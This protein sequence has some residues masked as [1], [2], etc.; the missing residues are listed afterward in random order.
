MV[1]EALVIRSGVACRGG[2]V[3]YFNDMSLYS[4]DPAAM[5]SRAVA[6]LVCA[7]GRLL[8]CPVDLTRPEEIPDRPAFRRISRAEFGARSTG[9][10]FARGCYFSI[11]TGEL[12]GSYQISEDMISCDEFPNARAYRRYL[13]QK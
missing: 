6:I 12:R 3:A 4:P 11:D 10:L 13:L 2:F 1:I 5:F 8:I 9:A 7:D